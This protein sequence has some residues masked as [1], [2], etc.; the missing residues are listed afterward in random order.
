[1]K[2]LEGSEHNEENQKLHSPIAYQMDLLRAKSNRMRREERVYRKVSEMMGYGFFYENFLENMEFEVGRWDEIFGFHQEQYENITDFLKNLD[3]YEK[4]ELVKQKETEENTLYRELK[5]P[6]KNKDV[7]VSN[8]VWTE[9]KDGKLAERISCFCNVSNLK[10]KNEELEFL[11]YYDMVTGLYNRNY[12]IKKINDF[13]VE[14]KDG[15]TFHTVSVICMRVHDLKKVNEGM[16]MVAGDEVLQTVGFRLKE[17][18]DDHIVAARIGGGEFC[19]G[20]ADSS[21][22]RSVEQLYARISNRMK[23][24]IAVCEHEP[25]QFTCSFGVAEYPEAGSNA[26]EL[27][28]NAQIVCKSVGRGIGNN[29]RFYDCRLVNDFMEKLKIEQQ[30]KE[31]VA[32][33][34]FELFFQPQYEIHSRRLRGAETLLRWRKKDGTFVPNNL[35]IPIAEQNGEILRIGK[36][37]LRTAIAFLAKW[38]REMDFSGV[39]SINVST[40]QLKQEDFVPHLLSLVEEFRVTPEKLEIE[41]TE[42]VV[43]EDLELIVGKLRLLRGFGIRVSLDDFGTGFSSLTYLKDLPIDTLKI[44]KTFIDGVITDSSTN[45]ITQSVVEMVRQLGLE[46]VAEG[47]ETEEQYQFLEKIRCDNIQGY[48]LGKPM[49]EPQ[50]VEVYKR[51][52]AA[53]AV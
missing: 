44:D 9:Q 31:T 23:E 19:I 43:M 42:S 32:K 27:I 30:L 12:F 6:L 21:G 51:E 49:P 48:L 53:E 2:I 17:F 10:Q 41:I 5:F 24:P 45:I 26:M 25:Q 13:L 38:E 50:F 7:W 1:M 37:V 33:K 4:M 35:Y 8:I 34:Q 39:L 11:A 3:K 52:Q 15:N 18:M 47:V 14:E 36:W 40:I 22:S 20:I 16:G 29:L 28:K 46:T